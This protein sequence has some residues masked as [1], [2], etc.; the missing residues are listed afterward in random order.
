[1]LLDIEAE[2][3]SL[4]DIVVKKESEVYDL[5]LSMREKDRKIQ[6]LTI[7]IK[8]QKKKVESQEKKV[9][10]LSREQT[11][12]LINSEYNKQTGLSD[13][14]RNPLST[15]TLK[16]LATKTLEAVQLELL[17]EKQEEQFRNFEERIDKSDSIIASQVTIIATQ[18]SIINNSEKTVG[19]LK[20]KNKALNKKA[21]REKIKSW[22]ITAGSALVIGIIIAN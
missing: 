9:M 8:S 1:M 11:I 22:I 16:F 10:D 6:Q 14:A 3:D 2:N 19:I 13:T 5:K 21:K 18:R 12:S 4:E 20:Q 7:D 17:V 15:P